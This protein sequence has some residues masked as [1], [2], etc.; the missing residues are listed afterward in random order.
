MTKVLILSHVIALEDVDKKVVSGFSLGLEGD[1]LCLHVYIE[2]VML[3]S[4]ALILAFSLDRAS[5]MKA[6]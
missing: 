3:E 1:D 5:P 4:K 6:V 2:L